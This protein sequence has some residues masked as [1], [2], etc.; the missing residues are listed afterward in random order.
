LIICKSWITGR[1]KPHRG[2]QT[3]ISIED[4][5]MAG[6]FL[7]SGDV[8]GECKGFKYKEWIEVLSGS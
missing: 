2:L 7:K 6:A 1:G 3:T 8:K 5:M 4:T